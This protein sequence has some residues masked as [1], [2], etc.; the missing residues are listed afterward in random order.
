MFG[1]FLLIEI[2]SKV[3]GKLVAGKE[4]KVILNETLGD[5]AKEL[6]SDFLKK[7][8]SKIKK[9]ISK[10]KLVEDGLLNKY[11][12]EAKLY[13]TNFMMEA[14]A[15]K[16]EFLETLSS[17]IYPTGTSRRLKSAVKKW[18]DSEDYC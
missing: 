17:P 14:V 18:V 5:G 8:L 4:M 15:S 11:V 16:I 2:A 12:C 9:S 3:A 1:S 10:N 6:S 7:R 13:A